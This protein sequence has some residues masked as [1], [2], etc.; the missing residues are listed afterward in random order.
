VHNLTYNIYNPLYFQNLYSSYY[1]CNFDNKS[2]RFFFSFWKEY[3]SNINNM[4]SNMTLY[5]SNM[6][7]PSD[8]L[9]KSMCRCICNCSKRG[10]MDKLDTQN[11]NYV[12]EYNNFQNHSSLYRNMIWGKSSN[13]STLVRSSI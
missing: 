11:C 9:G 4:V 6:S 12:G 13:S 8:S 7:L 2:F 1:E 5:N 10:K 3:T